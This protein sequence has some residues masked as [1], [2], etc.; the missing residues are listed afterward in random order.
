MWDTIKEIYLSVKK[1]STDRIKSPF[2]GVF[3][4]TWLVFNWEPV[5]VILFSELKMEQRIGFVN[6]VYPIKVLYPLLT[7][8][9]LAF[10]LPIIN[11]KFTFLQ[12]KPISRTA[13]I[14]AIRRKRALL[15]D[16]SVERY[17]AKRDVTYDRHVAGAEKEIQD[18]HEEIVTSKERV[19]ELNAERERLSN[20]L[21]GVNS[22]L[23][24]TQENSDRFAGEARESQTQVNEYKEMIL[25]LQDKSNKSE[26]D[27][28]RLLEL[29]SK[30]EEENSHMK[31]DIDKY[32]DDVQQL[33]EKILEQTQLISDLENEN[34][35]LKTELSKIEGNHYGSKGYTN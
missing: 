24:K 8:L 16:I 23:K 2:Y 11:E 19:G 15:A 10:L 33:N 17:R 1:T 9:F 12:S 14:L 18:M 27:L 32:I 22:L 6:A 34:V 21:K 20:E 28:K 5:A 7:A 29:S 25:I 35:I 4:L 26:F 31:M 30:V 13:V 3:I